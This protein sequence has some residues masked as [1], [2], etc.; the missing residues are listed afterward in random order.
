[1]TLAEEDK[2]RKC[3]PYKDDGVQKGNNERRVNNEMMVI[4]VGIGAQ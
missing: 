4:N 1:M 2:N 3:R